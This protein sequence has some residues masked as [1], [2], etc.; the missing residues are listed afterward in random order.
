MDLRA[1]LVVKFCPHFCL[2]FFSKPIYHDTSHI[3]SL[4]M[5]L[6]ITELV[7]LPSLNFFTSASE[8]ARTP[9]KSVTFSTPSSPEEPPSPTRASKSERSNHFNFSFSL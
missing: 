3:I 8:W 9:G 6:Y 2:Q 1:H 4:W 7:Y 5:L